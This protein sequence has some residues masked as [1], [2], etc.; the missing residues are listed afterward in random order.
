MH[1]L[2]SP[3]VFQEPG[4][5]SQKFVKRNKEVG[6]TLLRIPAAPVRFLGH[7][8]YPWRWISQRWEQAGCFWGG[9]RVPARPLR[10]DVGTEARARGLTSALSS[11]PRFC[12]Q[13]QNPLQ[14]HVILKS[15]GISPF[16]GRA[17]L[18]P[19]PPSGA[20]CWDS[21]CCL[22]TGRTPSPT[23]ALPPVFWLVQHVSKPG[24]EL[25]AQSC[26]QW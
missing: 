24:Q 15:A 4:E 17:V 8:K 16:R 13:R 6:C 21:P 9:C 5:T 22:T 26:F 11:A 18:L 25:Q 7:L 2:Q 23:A 10:C 19:L 12:A 20:G 1:F 14:S 3:Y